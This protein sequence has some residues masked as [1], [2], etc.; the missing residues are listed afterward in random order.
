ME[1]IEV[2]TSM[3]LAGEKTPEEAM[4]D[5]AKEWD[6]ITDELGRDKQKRYFRE[7]LGLPV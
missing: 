1:A 5:A 7:S 3:A 2:Q 6:R 4:A